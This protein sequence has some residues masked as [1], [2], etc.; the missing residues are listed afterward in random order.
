MDDEP[1]YAS[2]FGGG[3]FWG[4]NDSDVVE[5]PAPTPFEDDDD[6]DA[7]AKDETKVEMSLM[8]SHCT[9]IVGCRSLGFLCGWRQARCQK[10][11]PKN[12]IA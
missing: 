10:E 11:M 8:V 4:R 5:V 9:L 7:A 6:D 3:S 1:K 2:G 12:L